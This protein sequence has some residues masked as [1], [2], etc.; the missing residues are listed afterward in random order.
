MLLKLLQLRHEELHL[1]NVSMKVVFES[2]W[3]VH[4]QYFYHYFS[5]YFLVLPIYGMSYFYFT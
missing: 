2:E 3:F 5:D 4:L 1:R